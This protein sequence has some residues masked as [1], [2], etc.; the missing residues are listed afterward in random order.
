MVEGERR[1]RD[2]E[3][4]LHVRYAPEVKSQ[5]ARATRTASTAHHQGRPLCQ[6][7]MQ[8]AL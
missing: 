3:S 8:M 6:V 4:S 2:G 7:E 1:R 5:A